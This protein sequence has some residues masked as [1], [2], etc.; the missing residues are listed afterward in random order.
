ME[1]E[2]KTMVKRVENVSA[3]AGINMGR[4]LAKTMLRALMILV[5]IQQAYMCRLVTQHVREYENTGA[6]WQSRGQYAQAE[7]YVSKT[8][9]SVWEEEE[10]YMAVWEK[11]LMQKEE[12][13]PGRSR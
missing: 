3:C 10:R 6:D 11:N 12:K 1:N 8:S 5:N 9:R 7:A 2:V 13:R 4:E